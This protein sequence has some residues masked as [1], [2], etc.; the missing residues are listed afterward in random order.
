[1]T[2]KRSVLLGGVAA[3]VGLL[4]WAV[5]AAIG[6]TNGTGGGPVTSV[7]VVRSNSSQITTS[8]TF[9]NLPGATVK[10]KV[11]S[12]QRALILARYSAESNC[13]GGAVG[14][15]CSARVL[16]G[17]VEAAPV[18]GADFAFDSVDSTDD[19]SC[20]PADCG[21]ESH[22][23]DRSRGPLGPG[24]YTVRVQWRIVNGSTFRLD[25]WS[26]TVERV[27]IG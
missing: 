10:V 5:P 7:K 23:M 26:L 4:I 8:T 20:L 18:S 25:D 13:T 27:K 24:T 17:G 14:S 11:P 15:W 2:R 9:V 12:G 21:W 16:I 1:M 3:L 22:S 6:L 19:V